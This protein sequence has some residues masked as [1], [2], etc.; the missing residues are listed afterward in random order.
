L[1]EG[2]KVDTTSAAIALLSYKGEAVAP[3]LEVALARKLSDLSTREAELI[4]EINERLQQGYFEAATDGFQF[5]PALRIQE[6]F[7]RTLEANYPEAG[8]AFLNFAKT[9]WS[10]K[11]LLDEVEED[12][13]LLAS[14]LLSQ[15]ERVIGPVFFPTPGP[16]QV[17]VAQRKKDQEM[18]LTELAPRMD[19]QDFLEKNPILIRERHSQKPKVGCMLIPLVLIQGA[20]DYIARGGA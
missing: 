17:P 4:P 16:M 14:A 18:L 15:L 9:Y 11:L 2:G 13:P 3:E 5:V 12:H 10:L 6:R 7:G 8:S 19:V 1:E 20:W